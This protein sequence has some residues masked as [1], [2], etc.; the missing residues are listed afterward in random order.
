MSDS[1]K[2]FG[3]YADA[4]ESVKDVQT[5]KEAAAKIN[6]CCDKMEELAAT[7]AKLPKINDPADCEKLAAKVVPEMDKDET[8]YQRKSS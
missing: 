4:I 2:L 3:E 1:V 8:R 7:I 5:G 6:K